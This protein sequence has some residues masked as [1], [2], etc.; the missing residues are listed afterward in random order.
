MGYKPDR[1][2]RRDRLLFAAV[3]NID[4]LPDRQNLEGLMVVGVKTDGEA[5]RIKPVAFQIGP[6]LA[7]AALAAIEARLAAL[8]R[9]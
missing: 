8:S 2:D 4:A 1:P 5:G 7:S 9:R 3:P 6:P